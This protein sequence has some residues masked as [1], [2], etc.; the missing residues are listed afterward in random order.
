MKLNITSGPWI[1]ESGKFNT[2]DRQLFS[3]GS[4]I[5][6]DERWYIA[7][8]QNSC[9]SHN[10]EGD[11]ESEANA[12]A[13]VTAVN[14]TYHKGINP[15]AVPEMLAQLKN[16]V[17]NTLEVDRLPQALVKQLELTIQKATL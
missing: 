2:N 16:L 3:T 4:I 17:Y 7:E 6:K 10:L 5:S 1:Y 12:T 11:A 13:I 15:E 14:N 9:G 8:I